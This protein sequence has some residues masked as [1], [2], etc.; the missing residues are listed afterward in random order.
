MRLVK[1]FLF[2]DSRKKLNSLTSRF[3]HEV[4]LKFGLT[5]PCYKLWVSNGFDHANWFGHGFI[6]CLASD[7]LCPFHKTTDDLWDV[8]VVFFPPKQIIRDVG[9]LLLK[10]LIRLCR[11]LMLDNH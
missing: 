11:R 3:R 9:L 6:D 5:M 8:L 4:I 2:V 10:S 1:D 7:L